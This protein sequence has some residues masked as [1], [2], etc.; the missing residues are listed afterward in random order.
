MKTL[1]KLN[2]SLFGEDGASSGLTNAFVERWLAANPGARVIER[3]LAKDPVPHLT[4]EVFATFRTDPAK[5]SAEE[6]ARVALSDTL[7][8]ELRR[9]DVLVIGLPMYNFAVPSTLKAYF[10]HVVRARVTFRYTENGP[11]GLLEGKKAYVLAA[12]GGVYAGDETETAWVR[13]ILAFI[14]IDDVELVVAEGLA[15]ERS[16]DA[17]LDGARREIERLAA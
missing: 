1:L 17:A 12:C 10:D 5:R 9:A 8:D 6:Q 14:G 15:S 3:D 11:E 4:A 2:A 16:R 13:Q 7:V